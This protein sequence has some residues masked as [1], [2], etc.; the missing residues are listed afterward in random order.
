MKTLLVTATHAEMEVLNGL[1][2]VEHL[3][4]GPGILATAFALTRRIAEEKF[5]LIVNAGVAGAFDGEKLAVGD[6]VW[7]SKDRVSDMGAEDGPVFRDIIEIGLVKPE[8]PPFHDGWIYGSV[9]AEISLPLGITGVTGITVNTCHGEE[10][11][12]LKVVEK[13][14]P[15]IETM[16][17]AAVFYVCTLLKV[18]FLCIRGISNR[19][20]RRNKSAWNIPLAMDAVRRTLVSML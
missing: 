14:Q 10:Q 2:G 9:P 7:I 20:E 3:V 19:V 4:T 8:E 1:P 11:S 6:V 13:Y 16:E 18:P 12:I 5:D 17:T 15:D